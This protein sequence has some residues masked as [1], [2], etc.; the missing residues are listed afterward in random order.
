MEYLLCTNGL[1][2]QYGRHKAVD[3]VNIHIRQGDIYGLIGRN[4]A[5]KT[6]ILKIISGLA[7]PTAG[8]FTLFGKTGKNVSPYMS[9][10][11]T[12]IEAP[13]VYPNMSARENLKLKCLAMGVR[14]KG[15]IDDLLRIVGLENTG[16]KKIRNF[17]ASR[18]S[19]LK[20]EKCT[21]P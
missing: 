20:I 4:G 10:I 7:S 15:C 11:G 2:K 18:Q 9:R 13:G 17:S 12:L 6:T 5:G 3:S 21:L 19:R 16:R 1:T 8:D 14:K